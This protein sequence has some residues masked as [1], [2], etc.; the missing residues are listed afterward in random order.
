MYGSVS[1]EDWA[2]ADADAEAAGALVAAAVVGV[3]EADD[4]LGVGAAGPVAAGVLAGWGLEDVLG[5]VFASGSTYCELP[6]DC[7]SAALG[8]YRASATRM[9]SA[10]ST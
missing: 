5:V 1:L 2:G 9:A 6:A 7:A 10:L 8:T 4:E 3:S